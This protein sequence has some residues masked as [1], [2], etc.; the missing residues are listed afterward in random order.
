MGE[1]T[2]LLKTLRSSS[3]NSGYVKK[4]VESCRVQPQVWLIGR[5]AKPDKLLKVMVIFLSNITELPVTNLLKFIRSCSVRFPI[6]VFNM[7]KYASDWHLSH[8]KIEDYR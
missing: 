1:A 3:A 7:K 5:L 4:V 6:K 8:L 2:S